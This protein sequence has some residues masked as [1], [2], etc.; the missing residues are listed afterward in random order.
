MPSEAPP[1]EAK[2]G[3]TDREIRAIEPFRIY[4]VRHVQSANNARSALH[5]VDKTKAK[6][7]ADPG[8]TDVGRRQAA[9]AGGYFRA[10]QRD[11]SLPQY[12][13]IVRL[14]VS[15][16]R[17]ALETVRSM[18]VAG[19]GWAVHGSKHLHEA[20]GIF[21][22][23]RAQTEEGACG[24]ALDDLE[25]GLNKQ[26]V[27]AVLADGEQRMA[28]ANM[29]E[30]GL[31]EEGKGWWRGGYETEEEAEARA[32]QEADKIWQMVEERFRSRRERRQLL[33][34]DGACLYITHGLFHDRLK[35]HLVG[36]GGAPSS[37]GVEC[38]F[39]TCNAGVDVY[40]FKIHPDTQRRMVAV[41]ELN[42]DH[43]LPEELRM[44]G[45]CGAFKVVYHAKKQ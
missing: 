36:N 17:R 27:E 9:C 16:M 13:K 30:L 41:V 14:H 22:G 7:Q 29:E 2:S 34:D 5:A 3:W 8:I 4:F 38:H 42:N 25:Y 35:R 19:E 1:A 45:T 33:H 20:G 28:L 40:D 15:L 21:N 18:D 39:P 26:G 10:I 11:P 37:N 12:K 6:R 23:D 32:A 31:E 44:G 24:D 43:Y